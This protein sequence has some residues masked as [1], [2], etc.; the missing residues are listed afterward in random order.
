MNTEV[1][2]GVGAQCL[3]RRT[4]AGIV[5][6]LLGLDRFGTVFDFVEDLVVSLNAKFDDRPQWGSL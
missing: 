2:V 1:L 3:R 4:V 6:G 5:D